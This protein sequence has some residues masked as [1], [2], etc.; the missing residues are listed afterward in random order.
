MNVLLKKRKKILLISLIITALLPVGLYFFEVFLPDSWCLPAFELARAS[1]G[2]NQYE[3]QVE[4]NPDAKT[5]TC[6]Q[7]V[8]YI[9]R[10][11][12]SLSHLYF[13]LH[14]NAYR[15]ENKPVFEKNEMEQAYPDGFS[16]GLLEVDEVVIDGEQAEYVVGGFS[17]NIL[18]LILKGSLEP[19][20]KTVIEMDYRV[21]L[22]YCLGRFGYG[23]N[24]YK[25]VNWYPIASVYDERGWNL[26]RYY[27][28][29]DPFY[30]DA[31]NYRVRIQAD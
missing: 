7:K 25:A 21:I 6:H 22:P 17:E 2:L 4:F 5:L 28:I 31:A 14:P 30:S 27:T 15:Y 24:M 23:K 11:Q 13:H 19:G 26:D 29:G 10:S 9:N 18:M 3:I 20:D 12:D 8:E 16:P 1:R